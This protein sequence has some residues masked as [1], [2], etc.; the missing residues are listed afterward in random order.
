MNQSE[1][2]TLGAKIALA[3]LP[4]LPPELIKSFNAAKS[5]LTALNISQSDL[6]LKYF[7]QIAN[8]SLS[9]TK[10][11]QLNSA[12]TQF[13]TLSN[14]DFSSVIRWSKTMHETFSDSFTS[15]NPPAAE[16]LN[17]QTKNNV[18]KLQLH[19]DNHNNDDYVTVDEEPI[20]EFEIPDSIAIPIGSNR[21]RIKTEFF[22]TILITIFFAFLNFSMNI[23]QG[24][25][26]EKNEIRY[27]EKQLQLK[28]KENKAL[29]TFLESVDLSASSGAETIK[30]LKES[31]LSIESSLGS[32]GSG[33]RAD[34]PSS[35]VHEES[36]A[37]DASSTDSPNGLPNTA[38]EK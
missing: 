8:I 11:S 34:S 10:L 4:D 5:A 27:Q 28:R 12:L 13:R 36:P 3:N 9:E 19:K 31:I 32:F 2:E 24:Y 38:Y 20:K 21:V 6:N 15:K 14:A 18:D 30:N 1:F 7:S 29:R 37:P 23:Y 17:T 16:S 26:N 25:R 22:I 33:D 35:P